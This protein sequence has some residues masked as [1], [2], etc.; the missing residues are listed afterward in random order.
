MDVDER[1]EYYC[2]RMRRRDSN[3]GKVDQSR[4][5]VRYLSRGEKTVSRSGGGPEPKYDRGLGAKDGRMSRLSR[6][7]GQDDAVA[8]GHEEH[9]SE[10]IG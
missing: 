5:I 6:Y 8:R 3:G 2:M 4:R 1:G 7:P 10:A 9:G